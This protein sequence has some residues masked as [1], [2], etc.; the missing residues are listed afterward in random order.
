MHTNLYTY[1][2]FVFVYFLW[3]E[4][5]GVFVVPQGGGKED[6]ELDRTMPG[7]E[8]HRFLELLKVEAD[9]GRFFF[10]ETHGIYSSWKQR[11]H[12]NFYT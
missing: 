5:D 12:V 8:S 1:R 7:Q 9:T 2:Y 11:L 6:D 3:V 4:L 10:F